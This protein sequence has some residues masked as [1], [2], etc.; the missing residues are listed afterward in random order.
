MTRMRPV[1]RYVTSPTTGIQVHVRE[2]DGPADPDGSARPVILVHGLASSSHI[3]DL[4]APIL[5]RTRRVA[6]YDLRGHG[7]TAKPDDGYDIATMVDDGAGIAQAIQIDEP[8]VVA[9]HSWGATVALHWTVQHPDHVHATV[10]VD[11]A[12]FAFRDAPDASW[13]RVAQRLAPPVM[14]GMT[15][16][17]LVEHSR[18]AL[19]FLDDDFR[20]RYFQALMDVA[21]DGTIR[22]RLSREHHMRILRAMWDDDVDAAFGALRRPALALLAQRAETDAAAQQMETLRRRMVERIGAAQPLLSVRWLANTIHDIPLQRPKLLAEAIAA[23][24]G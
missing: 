11:G 7:E 2:W 22:A 8:Y 5:A 9:G 21:P 14:R 6:S 1:D 23:F 10:L 24:A 20:R 4:C 16:D 19:G 3:F 18:G 12:F 13:E 15:L 17:G